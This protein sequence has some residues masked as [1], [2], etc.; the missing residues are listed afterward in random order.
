M[1][2]S[3]DT[4]NTVTWSV[5]GKR[6]TAPLRIVHRDSAAQPRPD[7]LPTSTPTPA[8]LHPLPTRLPT[9]P[10]PRTDAPR[11]AA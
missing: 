5:D 9:R 6:R 1:S 8:T 10:Q 7:D 3:A 4:E 11:Q 2:T